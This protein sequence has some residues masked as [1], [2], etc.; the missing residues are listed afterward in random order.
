MIMVAR[1]PPANWPAPLWAGMV[2]VAA[3][4][5]AVV[6]AFATATVQNVSVYDGAKRRRSHSLSTMGYADDHDD[7]DWT[8]GEKM[9]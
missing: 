9:K 8:M 7:G 4:A 5:K 6:V 1:L 2:K 3:A